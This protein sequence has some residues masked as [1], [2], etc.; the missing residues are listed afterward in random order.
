MSRYKSS[1]K[2]L[3][4]DFS[5]PPKLFKSID[6]E[7]HFDVDVCATHENAKCERY[8]TKEEDGLS[9]EWFGNVWC[10]P[11]YMTTP[12]QWIKKALSSHCNTVMLLNARTSSDWFH[13]YLYHN[14]NIEIRFLEGAIYLSKRNSKSMMLVIIRNEKV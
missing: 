12:E 1:E 11:S 10:C 8:Y 13:K 6:K 2:L 3:M 4:D 5:T 9:R 14:P 7:F